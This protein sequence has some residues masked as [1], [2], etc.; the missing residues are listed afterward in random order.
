MREEDLERAC[1]TRGLV[2]DEGPQACVVRLVELDA[3][4]RTETTPASANLHGGKE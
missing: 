3:H 4:E 2:A 1:R